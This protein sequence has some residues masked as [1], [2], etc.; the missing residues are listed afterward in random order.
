MF[1]VKA[2]ASMKIYPDYLVRKKEEEII[3][4]KLTIHKL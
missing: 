2:L 4:I 3:K 1:S